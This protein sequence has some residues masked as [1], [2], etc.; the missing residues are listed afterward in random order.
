MRNTSRT[1]M[2]SSLTACMMKSYFPKITK[3]KLPEMPGS[4]MVHT[5]IAPQ[6]P[7]NQRASVV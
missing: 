7:I 2:F 1:G 4:I 5:A 3:M 6:I